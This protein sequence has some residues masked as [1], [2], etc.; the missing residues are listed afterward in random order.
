MEAG[1]C[2][3]ILHMSLTCVKLPLN[4]FKLADSAQEPIC[5]LQTRMGAV[6]ETGRSCGEMVQL[7]RSSAAQRRMQRRLLLLL[8][9]LLSCVATTKNLQSPRASHHACFTMRDSP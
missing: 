4:I 3:D 5:M 8:L 6:H 1:S 9:V 7:N 2:H